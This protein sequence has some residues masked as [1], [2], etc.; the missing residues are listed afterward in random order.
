MA[1]RLT[2]STTPVPVASGTPVPLTQ[3]TTAGAT[4]P[5]GPGTF[6]ANCFRLLDPEDAQSVDAPQTFYG[7]LQGTGT[8]KTLFE[9]PLINNAGSGFGFGNVPGLADAGA[10]LGIAGVFPDIG[11]VLKIPANQ[12]G[13]PFSS[14]GFVK[15]YTLGAAASPPDAQPPDRALLDIAVVHLVL[16]YAANGTEYSGNLVLDATPSAPNWSITLSNLSFQA[17]VDGMGD[18]P[19]ITVT[20]GFQ[21]GSTIKP[22]F[23][24]LQVDYGS[25]LSAVKDL[26]TG[27][28][29]LASSLGGDAELNVGFSGNTLTV[30]QGFTLPTIPLG[31]GEICR[32]SNNLGFTATIPSSLELSKRSEAD[33]ERGRI[34]SSGSYR[35]W[36]GHL[37]RSYWACR[38]AARM[39]ISKPGSVWGF[40]SASRSHRAALRLL[41]G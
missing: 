33:R 16:A 38:M 4:P 36:Q 14:D 39:F 41:S 18:D 11:N 23:T 17:K 32:I 9:H 2:G 26:M 30:Q 22:G 15:T 3:G 1:R 24:N 35:R 8:S 5:P 28:S 27:L 21:A 12:G 29:D 10:L 19:L 40:R 25:A 20:G 13:L 6:A 31:F 7:I 34:P 37:A